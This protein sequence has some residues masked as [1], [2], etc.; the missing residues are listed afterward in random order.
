MYQKKSS[1]IKLLEL[2]IAQD[3]VC[4]LSEVLGIICIEP[5]ISRDAISVSRPSLSPIDNIPN[6]FLSL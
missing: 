3:F 4:T 6:L 5:T 2:M 1:N